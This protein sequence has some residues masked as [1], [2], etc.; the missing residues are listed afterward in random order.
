MSTENGSDTALAPGDVPTHGD[1]SLPM[2]PPAEHPVH[3]SRIPPGN[4]AQRLSSIGHRIIGPLKSR[5]TRKANEA[6]ELAIDITTLTS[7]LEESTGPVR[8]E[9]I[10]VL[11]S[12]VLRADKLLYEIEAFMPVIQQ[13]MD[14]P[15]IREHEDRL[16]LHEELLRH[17]EERS[18]EE[19]G[20]KLSY[21]L[22][23]L[24]FGLLTRGHETPEFVP[25][26]EEVQE[27]HR[28]P[29]EEPE[30]PEGEQQ[31]MQP[32]YPI[33]TSSGSFRASG[34]SGMM[35][36]E[37]QVERTVTT[38]INIHNEEL[39]AKLDQVEKA[40]AEKERQFE[41]RTRLMAEQLALL[42]QKV[43]LENSLH[44]ELSHVERT[45][46]PQLVTRGTQP[47]PLVQVQHLPI[48]GDTKT[49]VIAEKTPVQS[50]PEAPVRH[51]V[52]APDL[53][54]T[55]PPTANP[56]SLLNE[57]L[58]AIS[59]FERQASQPTTR[60]AG[61]RCV[62]EEDMRSTHSS[63]TSSRAQRQPLKKQ[64]SSVRSEEPDLDTSQ[65]CD[66]EESRSVSSGSVNVH[67]DDCRHSRHSHKSARRPIRSSELT[68]LSTV[69][70]LLPKYDGTG[71]WEAF[72][73]TF[74]AEIMSRRDLSLAQQHKILHDHVIGDAR[75]CVATSKDFNAAIKA[76][77]VNLKTAFGHNLSK[78]KLLQDFNK[79]SF[80]QSDPDKMRQDMATFANARMRLLEQGVAADDDRVTKVF[81]SK[82]PHTLRKGVLKL[83]QLRPQT[84]IDDAIIKASGDIRYMEL[85][86][87]VNELA[88]SSSSNEIPN[89]AL[90]HYA[91]ASSG[92]PKQNQPVYDASIVSAR[93]T[94]KMTKT[95][96]PGYYA[97]GRGLNVKSLPITF[98][99]DNKEPLSCPVC[100]KSGHSALRCKSNSAD[101]RSKVE[102]K[103]LC[104]LCLSSNHTIEH[105]KSTKSCIYCG[106][107]HHTGGCPLKEFYRD[108][109]N[110]PKEAK[111]RQTLFRERTDFTSVLNVDLPT[112]P[113]VTSDCIASLSQKFSNCLDISDTESLSAPISVLANQST[114]S[115]ETGTA[116]PRPKNPL[117]SYSDFVSRPVPHQISITRHGADPNSRLSFICPTTVDGKR[118]LAL[119]DTGATLSLISESRARQLGLEV[120]QRTELAIQGFC[121]RSV[122]PASIHA[123]TLKSGEGS[124]PLAFMITSTPNMPST[125]LS[126]IS[127]SSTDKSYLRDHGIDPSLVLS[128]NR[129][130]GQPIDMILGNDIISW[131][132]AHPDHYRLTLPSG[133]T[134]EITPA[135]MV[136]HP[137]PQSDSLILHATEQHV[138]DEHVSYASIILDGQEPEDYQQLLTLEIQQLWRTENLGIEDIMTAENNKKSS[139]DLL[140]QFN[141][142]ARY[143][144]NGDLE[145]AFP[146]NGNETRLAD[147]YAVAYKRLQSLMVTLQKGNNQVPQYAKIIDDQLSAGYIEKVTP[148][149]LKTTGPQYYIPHR[150][151]FKEDSETTK[152]RIVLDA[153]SHASGQLSLNDCLHAG[154]NMINKIFGILVRMR[155]SRYVI[156]AD[157]EKAFHQVRL[158]EEFRNTTMFLWL[159]DPSQPV[160]AS[161][162][163]VYRFTRIPFGVS[164]S[165]FLLAAYIYY[166]LDSH[167]DSLNQMIKDNIYVDNCLFTTDDRDEIP[168]IIDRS[169]KIFSDMKMNLREFIVNDRE[170]MNSL[171]P[172]VKAK[173]DIIKL[174][175]YLWD[176]VNDTLNIKIAQ[177]NIDHPTKRQVAS[178]FAETFDPLGLVTPI[179]VALKRLIQKMWELDIDWN[180]K[181]PPE[182]LRDWRIIQSAITDREI[183]CARPLR[184]DYSHTDFHM[185][186]FSDASQ[187][188]YGA[189]AYGCF[190]YP[191]KKPVINLITSKNK[192]KPSRNSNWSIPK[193]EL[194]GIEIGSNLARSI[195]DEI[196]GLTVT[197]I[198]SLSDSMIA[199][200]WLLSD[201]NTRVWV[202]NRCRSI[203]TNTEL[204]RKCGITCTF[205][206]CRT[207]DNTADITTRG[208][209]T[210]ILKGHKPWFH[211]PPMLL[212]DPSR[213][214][215][216]L[217]GTIS[218]PTEFR[219]LV[220]SEILP[221]AV[222][223]NPKQKSVKAK[224]DVPTEKPILT[225]Q[226]DKKGPFVPFES[227]N[228]LSKLCRTV[229]QLLRAFRFLKNKSWESEYMQKFTQSECPIYQQSVA[230]WIII[231]EHYA[232]FD[233]RGLS[234]PAG[235]LKLRLDADGLWR[236]VRNFRSPVLP[237]EASEPIYIHPHHPLAELLIRET[238]EAN[239]H[240]PPDYTR[241][242]LRT[243]YYIPGDWNMVQ[244]VIK[245]CVQ[246][247]RV[248]GKPYEYPFSTTLPLVRT[249]PA[250]PFQH[251]GLDYMGPLLFRNPDGSIGKAYV[252]IY[253]CLVTRGT[254]LRVI[255]DAK[256]ITYVLAL[257]TIFHQVGV[258]SS[259][260]RDNAE[261]FNLGS[262]IV[263]Q[264]IASFEPS[265]SLTAFLAAEQITYRTIT[266]LAPWQ[267]GVYE[268]VVGLVKGQL[269]KIGGARTFDYHS[270]EYIVS[271]CQSMVNNR[272]LTPFT[273]S[274]GD[275]IALRPL[276]FQYPG[277]L[278]ET[279]LEFDS[280]LVPTN[281][282]SAVREHLEKLY[283]AEEQMWKIWSLAYVSYLRE[284]MH[285]DKRCSQLKPQVGD[286]VLIV[287]TMVKRHK[288]PL[289]IIVAVRKSE[290]D[291]EI[292]SAD[293]KCRG[294]IYNR[295]V[296]QLVPLEVNPLNHPSKKSDKST[297]PKTDLPLPTP[298][299]LDPTVKYAPE[300]FPSSTM[301]N[302]LEAPPNAH[303]ASTTQ[304]AAS[305]DTA[306]LHN[307]GERG[308]GPEEP[309]E[310]PDEQFSIDPVYQDPN[311]SAPDYGRVRQ[312]PGRA[313]DYLPRTSKAGPIDYALTA[314][315]LA[316]PAPRECC[317]VH[318]A[319][320]RLDNFKIF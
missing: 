91:H 115:N 196:R 241:F 110:Y 27:A 206:H 291:G 214:P 67:D 138:P 46:Q 26:A 157:I 218:C 95:S 48:L 298:A 148:E 307:I 97:P 10:T 236:V 155:F 90:I 61:G 64:K 240:Q 301:P 150:A 13:T 140:E 21:A 54:S 238:H 129:Y 9:N 275:T 185:L 292:R 43:F 96:L 105:C 260:Y 300:L 315:A 152:V 51:T 267:G 234:F 231:R 107:M 172:E 221:S 156:V 68:K 215:C 22:R 208:M 293:V 103:K 297:D 137:M 8:E 30:M 274:P 244:S 44:H 87:E 304:G 104:P 305:A 78:D 85:E 204:F 41:H 226:A 79:L 92:K 124:P 74:S 17:Y 161:N 123:L 173:N 28:T 70:S 89:T 269:Y 1:P 66:D 16:Q 188:I 11:K 81:A 112:T 94:D 257:K 277:V 3:D 164:S 212:L 311:I 239:S 200:Y 7:R 197:T 205:H 216:K 230:R 302:I 98:P 45:P 153:S 35:Y 225:S 114:I 6:Q 253:T 201:E 281:T 77:F 237:S 32:T 318:V 207:Q 39:R 280:S 80:H 266:P 284:N 213:W 278:S 71:D 174:L 141:R 49:S 181:L 294:V 168:R 220:Y 125:T 47:S 235:K 116:G 211:G 99:F 194:I 143:D 154:T 149:M 259:I 246:C 265:R 309:L 192:I 106:G 224:T 131:W 59:R 118:L 65:R 101:F 170:I 82:L 102:Q 33:S 88:T 177:M 132:N 184:N 145:V 264:E 55:Q 14:L 286:V 272:P 56:P 139:D 255:P 120:L 75:C 320:H 18:T 84:T 147:N 86:Q 263:N 171:P 313:R 72:Y 249:T 169:R 251:S 111:P 252:L 243:K 165:P 130:A 53:S 193:I 217:E 117:E 233:S 93:F 319:M 310:F 2:G 163:Q 290:R 261:T 179:S 57:V 242:I 136:V 223:K 299:V 271:S 256:T 31:V 254:V 317:R 50:E 296:C 24:K 314:E 176:S 180:A 199:L 268:R 190:M 247:K 312:P 12:V 219:E 52:N 134:I 283:A 270:L 121:S 109:A 15:E 58:Q 316:P 182:A 175:G 119:V 29:Y 60:P 25:S 285:A 187:D 279:P 158:Q 23:A 282:E 262:K 142:T 250:K 122:S 36:D 73:D 306:G 42:N 37:T 191:N 228:S 167:P 203:K 183:C 295:A 289:G 227:T 40:H 245:R 38:F 20:L 209:P 276:D 160:S 186:I 108:L 76:T 83:L 222:A 248:N 159:K 5:I 62:S 151:V 100:S 166:C 232:E 287:T 189:L 69:L 308:E 127:L 133:R 229:V 273:R 303:Q 258:P 210:Y 288:W 162:L 126:A 135:G 19:R 202:A 113:A 63:R 178:K 4:P 128:Q 144:K 146:Y 34:L 195:I 198:R